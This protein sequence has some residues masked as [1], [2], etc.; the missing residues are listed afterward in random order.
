[1]GMKLREAYQKLDELIT[2]N[3]NDKLIKLLAHF[4]KEWVDLDYRVQRIEKALGI[5]DE[6][7]L[8]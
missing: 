2:I 4:I 5:K 6:I 7:K 1:M 8:G 3:P